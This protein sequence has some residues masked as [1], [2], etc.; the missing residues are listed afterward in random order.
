MVKDDFVLMSNIY[1]YIILYMIISEKVIIEISNRNIF[2][3]KKTLKSEYD[4]KIGLNEI[5]VKDLSNGSHCIVHVEC[6][7]CFEIKDMEY[8]SYLKFTKYESEIYCCKKCNNV[9]VRKTNLEKYG[10]VC[11]SQL[12]SN[13][14]M[15]TDKWSNK[16]NEELDS[17]MKIRKETC[18]EKYGVNSYVET[19]EYKIKSKETWLEKYGVENPSYSEIS[20]Q[21]RVESKLKKFGFINNSQTAEWKNRISEIW[22]NRTTDDILK[23]NKTRKETCLKKYGVDSYLKTNEYKI[24][25]RNTLMIRYGV[26]SPMHSDILFRRQQI[27]ALKIKKYIDTELTYQGTYELDFLEKF[28][29]RIQIVK[30]HPIQYIFN[31]KIHYYHPDFYLP[32]YNLVVEIKSLYTYNFDLDKNLVKRDYVIDIGYNFMFIIDKDYSILESLIINKI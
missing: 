12:Q 27:S 30:I 22:N 18:M 23:I 20:K 24:R 1:L 11:N 13:K 26:E 19:N 28:H 29:N 16:S 25:F 10:V 15:V 17:I 2:H 21:K 3:F 6:D 9:K 7:S 31:G 8:R 4:L 32:Q 14:K 5:L